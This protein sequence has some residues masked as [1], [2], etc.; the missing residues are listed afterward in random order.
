MEYNE[1]CLL[2]F[3]AQKREIKTTGKVIRFEKGYHDIGKLVFKEDDLTV[4]IEEGAY[5]DG[6]L[7]F[8]GCNRLKVCGGGIL[9]N[10]NY[11]QLKYRV[12]FD[13]LGCTDV[14]VEDLTIT[15]SEFWNM[16]ILGCENVTVHNVKVIGYNVPIAVDTNKF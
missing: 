13:L 1:K 10:L 6:K 12:I 11:H 5:L 9:A 7:E 2:V 15:D 14:V 8:N 16:R 3:A 4:L